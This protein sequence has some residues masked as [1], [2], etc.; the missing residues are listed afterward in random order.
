MLY[1]FLMTPLT[2]PLS[3]L[4]ENM[5][6]VLLFCAAATTSCFLLRRSR[7]IPIVWLP[8][9]LVTGGYTLW[10][11]SYLQSQSGDHSP[12]AGY[13]G[14]AVAFGA[15]FYWPLPVTAIL[16][17]V[18]YPKREA[19]R[20]PVALLSAV[21]AVLV[22]FSIYGAFYATQQPLTFVVTDGTGAPI[23][24][25][26]FMRLGKPVPEAFTDSNGQ[27]VR[28]MEH[29]IDLQGAFSVDGYIRHS[30]VI[31]T[32]GN[33]L[34]VVHRIPKHGT[35]YETVVTSE[36]YPLSWSVRIPIMMTPEVPR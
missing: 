14:M 35:R 30:I 26:A 15:L 4:R 33:N 32:A 8:S 2:Q 25:V 11:V 34:N 7:W 29:G 28:R 23:E 16:L 5:A 21:S 18:A 19:W 27:L 24:K 10:L 17:L 31:N 20:L 22:P 9:L 3:F 13:L 6:L 12:E 1:A 36:L